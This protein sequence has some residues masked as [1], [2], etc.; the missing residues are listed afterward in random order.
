M[1]C[2]CHFMNIVINRTYLVYKTELQLTTG[3]N[4][5]VE[6]FFHQNSILLKSSNINNS[7]LAKLSTM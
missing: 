6:S 7:V 5:Q 3:K 2:T 1:Q 4:M